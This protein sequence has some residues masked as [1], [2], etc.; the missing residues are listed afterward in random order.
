MTSETPL[1]KALR[2]SSAAPTYFGSV[3]GK[4]LDGG[5]VANNPAQEL[6]SEVI[7]YNDAIAYKVSLLLWDPDT[8]QL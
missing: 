7:T 2:C 4:Y 8:W 5:L 3:D 6:I 1:W